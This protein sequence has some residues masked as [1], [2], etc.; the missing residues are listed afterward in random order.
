[1]ARRVGEADL[2]SEQFLLFVGWQ[3]PLS[4]SFTSPPGECYYC[5]VKRFSY[6]I[7]L[8]FLH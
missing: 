2:S 1:M 8:Q 6:V 5:D 3:Q 7:E 4:A